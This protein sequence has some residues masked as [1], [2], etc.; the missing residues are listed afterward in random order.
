MST[1]AIS[2]LPPEILVTV[3]SIFPS[4]TFLPR[5]ARVCKAWQVAVA[6]QR[7]WKA[8]HCC[9]Y[10]TDP[11]KWLG[12]EIPDWRAHS[13]A[14]FKF[15]QAFWQ[16]N[17]RSASNCITLATRLYHEKHLNESI[18]LFSDTTL[19]GAEE[20][21]NTSRRCSLGSILLKLKRLRE[22]RELVLPLF[23]CV[24]PNPRGCIRL[25][26]IAR[27]EGRMDEAEI[28][29]GQ[30]ALPP[31]A[32]IDARLGLMEAYKSQGKNQEYLTIKTLI[33]TER[34]LTTNILRARFMAVVSLDDC[35]EHAEEALNKGEQKD[36]SAFLAARA[37]EV[38][39]RNSL[40]SQESRSQSSMIEY[41]TDK[42]KK[43]YRLSLQH[44]PFNLRVIFSF[45]DFLKYEIEVRKQSEIY[46]RTDVLQKLREEIH[47]LLLGAVRLNPDYSH[48]YFLLGKTLL[49]MGQKEDALK[50]LVKAQ[51]LG[52]EDQELYFLL[53]PLLLKNKSFVKAEGLCRQ[54]LKKFPSRQTTLLFGQAIVGQPQSVSK[55][56]AER[57]LN[58]QVAKDVKDLDCWILLARLQEAQANH[59]EALKSYQTAYQLLQQV[60]TSVRSVPTIDQK[61]QILK[62]TA[63]LHLI[64]IGITRCLWAQ[65]K[66]QESQ[67][68]VLKAI[69]EYDVREGFSCA[70]ELLLFHGNP[71]P[72]P[73]LLLRLGNLY[74]QQYRILICNRANTVE[75]ERNTI[76]RKRDVAFQR[77]LEM[78]PDYFDVHLRQAEIQQNYGEL[79]VALAHVRKALHLDPDNIAAVEVFIQITLD[80]HDPALLSEAIRLA[81]AAISS[82]KQTPDE[83]LDIRCFYGYLIKLYYHQGSVESALDAFVELFLNYQDDNLNLREGKIVPHGPHQGQFLLVSDYLTLLLEQKPEFQETVISKIL[84]RN[85]RN[86]VMRYLRASMHLQKGNKELAAEEWQQVLKLTNQTRYRK[87]ILTMLANIYISLGRL[88]PA[89]DT[90]HLIILETCKNGGSLPAEEILNQFPQH[91]HIQYN[92]GVIHYFRQYQDLRQNQEQA[93]RYLRQ[94]LSL[95]PNHVK[96]SYLLHKL[97]IDLKKTDEAKQY[98]EQSK[99]YEETLYQNQTSNS[100]FVTLNIEQF[101][102]KS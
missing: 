31:N 67:N 17:Q 90:V 72:T 58:N 96:A 95:N 78:K 82:L 70:E 50:M 57:L 23:L 13:V 28:Y 102:E 93:V 59:E 62:K 73:P 11:L 4:I 38:Y 65:G 63:D 69:E 14:V 22:S 87:S 49:E 3:L 68:H 30:A 83:E 86:F 25:G 34:Q 80:E 98:Q 32:P 56:E 54:C 74:E 64:H 55:K 47:S 81:T 71:R 19:F 88:N 29:Y 45:V 53:I 76:A 77:A 91:F 61:E 99:K 41:H 12:P 40:Q 16:N 85:P 89:A 48:T 5:V 9:M 97:L 92:L 44:N 8:V 94:A 20:S 21:I 2:V 10:L 66:A 79:P 6:D 15:V 52:H 60:D 26:D 100:Q 75:E 42:V 51:E 27:E 36:L 1:P 43:F 37:C 24:P 35:Y 33:E 18:C 7:L 84:E 101:L 46:Y 39:C